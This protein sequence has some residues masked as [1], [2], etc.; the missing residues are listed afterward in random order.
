MIKI[1][2]DLHTHTNFSDGI[3]SPNE[4][5]ARAVD[6]GLSVLA[7][8]DH[9]TVDGC[10][11]LAEA[12]RGGPVEVIPGIELSTTEG[13]HEIHLLGLHVDVEHRRL[14]EEIARMRHLRLVRAEKTVDRL[15]ELGIVLD[16]DEIRASTRNG[17]IARPHIAAAMVRAG[18]VRNQAQAFDKYLGDG[19]PAAVPKNFLTPQD[20]IRL[21]REAGAFVS[22]A[23]PGATGVEGILEELRDCGMGGVEVWHPTHTPPQAERLLQQAES[24]GLVPTGGSD[25]HGYDYKRS[26]IFGRFGLTEERYQK[27]AKAWR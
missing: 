10:T 3:L 24:L 19:R 11:P 9:D 22:V 6:A 4:L 8:T 13:L 15:K 5:I 23:H 14:G 25:Y 18:S 26:S 7:L 1:H 17:L 2:A 16:L 20:G 21:L 12:A 27:L